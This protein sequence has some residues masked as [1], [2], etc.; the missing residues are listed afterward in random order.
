MSSQK[1]NLLVWSDKNK[2]SPFKVL[3]NSRDKFWFRCSECNHEDEQYLY[4][5]NLK[6][7]YYCDKKKIC[8]KED[9]KDCYKNSFASMMFI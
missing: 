4:Q 2:I 7:C 5:V 6:R 3:R 1:G 9:C 8:G